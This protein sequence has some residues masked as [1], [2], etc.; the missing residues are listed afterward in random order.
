M[1]EKYR[2]KTY[3]PR[4]SPDPPEPPVCKLFKR[5]KGCRYPALGF[6]CWHADGTCLK[7]D[8]EDIIRRLEDDKRNNTCTVSERAACTG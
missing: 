6:I 8:T 4:Y 7:T 3:A 1:Y 2:P 5:C